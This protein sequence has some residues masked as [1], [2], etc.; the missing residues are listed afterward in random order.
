MSP[1]ESPKGIKILFFLLPRSVGKGRSPRENS[2]IHDV[3][4]ERSGGCVV[5]RLQEILTLL[6]LT[7]GGVSQA[8]ETRGPASRL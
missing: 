8:W 6:V 7:S 5:W 1:E 3:P 2:G 4:W